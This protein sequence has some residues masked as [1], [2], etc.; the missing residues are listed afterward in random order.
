MKNSAST[1][2][3]LRPEQ[4]VRCYRVSGFTLIEMIIV[5]AIVA[6]LVAIVYPSY[7]EYVKRT[8]R[9]DMQSEMIQ[10]AQQLQS[11]YVIK[12]DYTG[13][14]L[15]YAGNERYTLTF[16]PTAQTWSMTA[17]PKGTQDGDGVLMLDS[18]GYKCWVKGQSTCI[19]SVSS[20]W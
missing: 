4:T 14:A 5:V 20:T 13:A 15:S 10:Q 12:H 2:L 11:Y 16:T 8:H 3:D 6:V 1:A 18:R 7:Q 17:T 9:T 19:L